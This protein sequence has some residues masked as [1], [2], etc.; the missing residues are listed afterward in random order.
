MSQT[1]FL[2]GTFAALLSS[3]LNFLLDILSSEKLLHDVQAANPKLSVEKSDG[4]DGFD[5]VGD[6]RK[7]FGT[8]PVVDSCSRYECTTN[9]IPS[10]AARNA[11]AAVKK[12]WNASENMLVNGF[13]DHYFPPQ[14]LTLNSGM[15]KLALKSLN[16]TPSLINDANKHNLYFEFMYC[17]KQQRRILKQN[18]QCL[19]SFDRQWGINTENGTFFSSSPDCLAMHHDERVDILIHN[20][21]VALKSLSKKKIEELTAMQCSPIFDHWYGVHILHLFV[22]DLIGRH[23]AAAIVF[24]EKCQDRCV[25]FL[26]KYLFVSPKF[27]LDLFYL[28]FT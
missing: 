9:D 20:E 28:M 26:K 1:V 17:I 25:L 13:A 22:I 16:V 27:S 6:R 10:F 5:V 2:F 23:N 14:L 15:L 11:A 4:F 21:Y 7:H 19:K 12:V 24:K 18:L 8:D 3:V